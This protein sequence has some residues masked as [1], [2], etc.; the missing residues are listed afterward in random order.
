MIPIQK[1]GDFLE[2]MKK[3]VSY[4]DVDGDTYVIYAIY[5]NRPEIIDIT[6]K[7]FL[8]AY[9]LEVHQQV[10]CTQHCRGQIVLPQL[11]YFYFDLPLL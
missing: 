7:N 11:H 4:Q 9:V 8:R 1:D 5:D 6:R 10:S 2:I 3:K